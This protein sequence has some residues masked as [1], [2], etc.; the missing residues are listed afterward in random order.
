MEKITGH[1]DHIIFE[2][3]ENGYTVLLLTDSDQQE[4]VCV[5]T[6]PGIDNGMTHWQ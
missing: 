5:G 1:V 6:I 4:I 3:K 2:N